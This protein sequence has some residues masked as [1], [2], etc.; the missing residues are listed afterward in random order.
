MPP[1]VFQIY[2]STVVSFPEQQWAKPVW[3]EAKCW[4]I[5]FSHNEHRPNHLS[6][7]WTPCHIRRGTT[8]ASP[9]FNV[10][11]WV[12]ALP[13]I[14]RCRRELKLLYFSLPEVLFLNITSPQTSRV[15]RVFPHTAVLAENT[16]FF[17]FHCSPGDY[18]VYWSWRTGIAI[19]ECLPLQLKSFGL[20]QQLTPPHPLYPSFPY[21]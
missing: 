6:W 10:F 21:N 4:K 5:L 7:I 18:F 15:S 13:W 8:M 3:C 16:N 11:G 1:S 20:V 12:V 9:Y 17:W 14:F 19:E 2:S